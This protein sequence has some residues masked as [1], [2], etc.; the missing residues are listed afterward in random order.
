M[1]HFFFCQL[2]LCYTPLQPDQA[3]Y[4][5]APPCSSLTVSVYQR[6]LNWILK[7]RKVLVPLWSPAGCPNHLSTFKAD[8]I[9]SDRVNL[10]TKSVSLEYHQDPTPG[11]DVQ[12]VLGYSNGPSQ[13]SLLQFHSFLCNALSRV[14]ACF[15]GAGQSLSLA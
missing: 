15:H 9:Q 12:P 14:L 5:T 3:G 7:V 10:I 11:L 13:E 4:G 1:T 2:C 6:S 8:P